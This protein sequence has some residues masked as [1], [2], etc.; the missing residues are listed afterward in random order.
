MQ[1]VFSRRSAQPSSVRVPRPERTL[2]SAEADPSRARL[3][4]GSASVSCVPVLE[5][6][7]CSPTGRSALVELDSQ[8]EFRN[9]AEQLESTEPFEPLSHLSPHPTEPVSRRTN[10]PSVSFSGELFRESRGCGSV[11][12]STSTTVDNSQREHLLVKII[13]IESDEEDADYFGHAIYG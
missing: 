5:A 4:T 9:S 6:N 13:Q 8:Q 7:N 11:E 10:G 2:S 12:Q 1:I 3:P